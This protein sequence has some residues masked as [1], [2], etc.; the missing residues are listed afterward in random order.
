M[1]PLKARKFSEESNKTLRPLSKSK[2]AEELHGE[3]PEIDIDLR[4]CVQGRKAV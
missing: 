2:S 3:N 1:T 4:E